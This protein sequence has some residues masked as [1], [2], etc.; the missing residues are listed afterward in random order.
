MTGYRPYHDLPRVVREFDVCIVPYRGT[1]LTHSC[2]PLKVYEYLATGKPIV[3]TALE[4][5]GQPAQVIEVA[6]DAPRFIAATERALA[7]PDAGRAERLAMAEAC[8]WEVR[9]DQF[10]CRLREA[11]EA[12][13]G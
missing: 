12:S 3:V 13:R 11:V 6:E 7:D 8:S 5:L 4:G 9:T 1:V 10:E 2:N